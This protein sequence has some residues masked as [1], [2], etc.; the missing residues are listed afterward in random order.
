VFRISSFSGN[1]GSCVA[2]DLAWQKSSFSQN[3]VNCVEV[4]HPDEHTIAVRNSNFPDKGIVTFTADE[5]NAFIKGA[6]A[7]EFDLQ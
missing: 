2:V 6:K 5:W 1:Q 4:Q 7:G 3:L